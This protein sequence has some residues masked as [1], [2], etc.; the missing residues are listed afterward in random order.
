MDGSV[1]QWLDDCNLIAGPAAIQYQG[2][3][4]QKLDLGLKLFG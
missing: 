2:A 3:I 4:L 1:E